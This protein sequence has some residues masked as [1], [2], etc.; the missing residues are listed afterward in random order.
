MEVH[1]Q[2]FNFRPIKIGDQF[3]IA[4]VIL[5]KNFMSLLLFFD[6]LS[7]KSKFWSKNEILVKNRNFGQK[8][9]LW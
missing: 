1:L 7:Q 8:S 3:F 4:A 5:C 9:R 2:H 6:Y